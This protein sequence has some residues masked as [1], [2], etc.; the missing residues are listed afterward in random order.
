MEVRIRLLGG[1]E[2][3]ADAARVPL[4]LVPQRLVAMLALPVASSR[5][6]IAGLLWP[7]VPEARASANLRST[8]HRIERVVPGLVECQPGVIRLLA[9]AEVDVRT[10]LSWVRRVG[11]DPGFMAPPPPGLVTDD[12]LPGWYEDWVL[13][14]RDHLR[15]VRQVAVE[16]MAE[17]FLDAGL[18]LPALDLAHIA[19][20]GDPLRES[21]RRLLVRL[22]LA[23][24]NLIEA[25]RVY[26]SYSALLADELGTAPSP[27]LRALLPGVRRVR[28]VA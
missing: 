28:T 3:S 8:L 27:Q 16:L 4:P 2:F 22:H 18:L 9:A 11:V 23:E 26:D 21:A 15:Q 14:E 1:F 7:E 5:T 17:R 6:Q 20:R 10:T 12:L 13:L 19:V 24:G 25:L